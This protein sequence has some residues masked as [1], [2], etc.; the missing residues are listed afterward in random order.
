MKI[1]IHIVSTT[2]PEN[3]AQIIRQQPGY[4]STSPKWLKKSST[5]GYR[6]YQRIG[7]NPRY[8]Y[9]GGEWLDASLEDITDP[10]LIEVCERC[11]NIGERIKQ[12]GK[13]NRLS[14]YTWVLSEVMKEFN[15]DI[16]N[17][18]AYITDYADLPWNED[19]TQICFEF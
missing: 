15:T 18:A 11:A 16:L 12:F 13:I 5:G 9:L 3:L 14:E 8:Q 4:S 6:L 1:D 10:A 17:A 19:R 2:L 7:Q